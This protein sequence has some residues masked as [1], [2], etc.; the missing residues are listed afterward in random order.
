VK[1]TV[2]GDADLSGVV[3][4][5][6]FLRFKAGFEGTQ[7]DVWAFGDFD[8]SGVV[9]SADFALYFQGY[10]NQPGGSVPTGSLHNDMMTFALD[11][12]LDTSLIPEPGSL[13]L[14]ALSAGLML[15]RRRR[16]S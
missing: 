2:I 1:Y 7:S 8:Y 4:G 5:L 9:D 3:N 6:D 15:R 10:L 12:G 14:V 13:S 16:R 11:Y